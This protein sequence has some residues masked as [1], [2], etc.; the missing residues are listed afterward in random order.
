MVVILW[1]SEWSNSETIFLDFNLVFT[2]VFRLKIGTIFEKLWE[3]HFSC[4]W[5][6][7]DILAKYL[8]IHKKCRKLRRRFS[9]AMDVLL[10][11][12]L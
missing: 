3:H 9:E 8:V 4:F 5:P 12:E 11:F 6:F 10:F 7:F 2:G 1:Y